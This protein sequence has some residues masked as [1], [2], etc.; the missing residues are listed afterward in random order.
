MENTKNNKQNLITE[1]STLY[2]G[3]NNG[4]QRYTYD[5]KGRMTQFELMSS[6]GKMMLRD[7][8][9]YDRNNKIVKINSFFFA[10]ELG[11]ILNNYNSYGKISEKTDY[12]SDGK[13]KTKTVFIYD[14]NQNVIQEILYES[15][16]LIPIQL[17]ETKYEYY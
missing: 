15:E 9:K 14:K 8:Y 1:Q 16:Y 10:G 12:K 6:E 3:E 4:F 11:F 7:V 2:Y 17:I 13:I 5:R